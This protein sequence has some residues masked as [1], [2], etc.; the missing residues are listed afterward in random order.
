[1]ASCTKRGLRN[2]ELRLQK[3]FVLLTYY[4]ELSFEAI[5]EKL[6]H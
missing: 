3:G 1:M 4:L 5:S 2:T 6:G